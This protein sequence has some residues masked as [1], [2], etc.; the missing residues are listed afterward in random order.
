LTQNQ[1]D[2]EHYQPIP[3]KLAVRLQLLLWLALTFFL[4]GIVT[5]LITLSKFVVFKNSFSVVGGVV[6]LIKQGQWLLFIVLTT[7]SIILPLL[8][9]IVLQMILSSR[10]STSVSIQKLLHWMHE[11]GRWAM[12]DVMVVAILIVTVKLGAI[13]SIEVHYGLYLFGIAVLLIMLITHQV[14]QLTTCQTD[15]EP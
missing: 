14:M 8:K 3:E 5:P 9:I 6:E 1:D 10:M 7:F 11:F 4:V 13:A 12:L 15:A 2:N